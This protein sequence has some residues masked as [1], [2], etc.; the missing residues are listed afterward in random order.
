MWPVKLQ[1]FCIAKN[2][3]NQVS[4]Q[5]TYIMGEKSLLAI[6]LSSVYYS[7]YGYD[8]KNEYTYS[9]NKPQTTKSVNSLMKWAGNSQKLMNNGQKTCSKSPAIREKPVKTAS[10]FH[11]NPVRK[12]VKKTDNM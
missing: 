10:R 5:A 3:F 12:A 7:E 2:I 8:S 1:S 11:I 6:H 4:K 9:K